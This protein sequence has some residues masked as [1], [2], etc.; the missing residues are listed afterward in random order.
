[1]FNS[2]W[3]AIFGD[4]CEICEVF[5]SLGLDE[6][7][8]LLLVVNSFSNR[9]SHRGFFDHFTGTGGVYA[10]VDGPCIWRVRL[11]VH[12]QQQLFLPLDP[13]SFCIS[14]FRFDI[15]CV[16]VHF[17]CL[18]VFQFS[19]L[20]STFRTILFL[21]DF[22]VVFYK[23]LLSFQQ[24]LPN[25]TIDFNRGRETGPTA[26]A[27]LWTIGKNRSAPRSISASLL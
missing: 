18:F 20:L 13:L 11:S 2:L 1:M 7:A 15:H 14:P 24:R 4:S 21:V 12:D 17:L 23:H 6:G 27:L 25:V 16:Y 22:V 10:C 9:G 26:I 5:Q 8:S 19:F 3:L